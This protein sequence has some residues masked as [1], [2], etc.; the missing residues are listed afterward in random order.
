VLLFADTASLAEIERL[1]EDPRVAG[2]TTNP[3]IF[4]AEGVHDPAAHA[5]EIVRL[6]DKPVSIDG[7]PEK[8]WDLGPNAI[9]KVCHRWTIHRREGRAF[10]YTAVVVPFAPALTA[11]DIV[12]VFAGRI[13]DTGQSP[14]MTIDAA[15]MS[16][17]QVLWASTR[18]PFNVVQAEQ[19]G[20]DI[21][22]I[23]PLLL[24]KWWEWQA[25]TLE[26]VQQE[27]VMQFET[28]RVQW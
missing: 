3:S 20:C 4:K 22:T 13:M 15:K 27:T 24:R 5:K 21:I 19:M 12:S 17:A 2:F 11:V 14:K 26:Q 18:E 9:P 1:N 10:N 23:S 6:T 8:V 16:G 28:D 7:P 25:K